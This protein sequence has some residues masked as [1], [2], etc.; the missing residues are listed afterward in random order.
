MKETNTLIT[1]ALLSIF[2]TK[3]RAIF[4]TMPIK[5]ATIASANVPLK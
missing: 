3:L 4:N 1:G 2:E 5:P